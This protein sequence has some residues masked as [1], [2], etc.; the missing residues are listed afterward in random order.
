MG[1]INSMPRPLYARK[2]PRYPLNKIGGLQ[3][4]SG[5][6]E[7]NLLPLSIFE[8]RTVKSA[9][10]SLYRLDHFQETEMVVSLQ[11]HFQAV[12]PSKKKIC[13]PERHTLCVALRDLK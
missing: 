2:E 6:F 12:N 13:D 5:C 1:V 9:A 8:P 7:E 11:Q 10:Y 4:R 3:N